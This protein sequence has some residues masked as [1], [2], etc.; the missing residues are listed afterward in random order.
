MNGN[1]KRKKKAEKLFNQWKRERDEAVSSL[2]LQK[3]KAFYLKWQEKGAYAKKPLPPDN[4]VEISMYK[5]AC[6]ITAIPEDIALKAAKWLVEHG[7]FAGI[8]WNSKEYVAKEETPEGCDNDC[9]HCEY[10]TCPK[11]ENKNDGC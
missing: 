2:D 1:R 8:D 10:A 6:E 7:Y 11:E 9:E 3:F 4:I 5:M